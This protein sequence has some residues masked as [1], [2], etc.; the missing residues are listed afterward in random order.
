[1]TFSFFP[2]ISISSTFDKKVS[3]LMTFDNSLLTV[4]FWFGS[5]P[6]YKIAGIKPLAL[7]LL[8]EPDVNLSLLKL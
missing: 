8:F 4:I 2:S 1:M 3:E 5:F 7:N 6:P